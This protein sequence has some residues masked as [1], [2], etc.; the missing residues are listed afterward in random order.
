MAQPVSTTSGRL[1]AIRNKSVN[2]QIFRAL[3]SLASA[4]LLIRVMGMLNQVVV[5]S[6]FGAGP[7]MDAYVIASAMP[8]LLASLLGGAIESS[9][10][11]V[12]ARV[13]AQGTK[14]QT[15]RLFSTLLNLF[16]VCTVLVTLLM[17]LFRAQV[18]LLSAPGSQSSIIELAVD[19]AP[20]IFPAFVLMVVINY[21]ECILNTEG[22]FGWP[23]YAGMLV[24]LTTAI[25]VFT[26][27]RSIGVVML[28]VGMMVGLCL[29]LCAFI[30]RARRAGLVY[31]F[32]LEVHNPEIGAIIRA[33]WPVLVGALIGQASNLIDIIFSSFLPLG[34]ISALNYSLK[35]TSVFTGVIFASVGRAVLPY[36]SR[37]AS[38]NDMKNFKETLRLYIWI[39]GIGTTILSVLMVVLAH[40]MVH[41]L[42]QRGAFT[43]NDTNRTAITFIG[44]AVGLTPIAFG[45]I[46]FRAFSALGKTRVLLRVTLFSL[47][48]NAIFDYIF[49]RIWQS[50]G[51]ALATSATYVC[52]T[53]I[54]F[55]TLRCMIG[56]LHMF[57]PPSEIVDILRK[58]SIRLG[59]SRQSVQRGGTFVDDSIPMATGK[60]AESSP[61][62]VPYS[63]RQHLIRLGI[64]IAVF[65][66]GVAGVFLNSLYALRISLASVIMLVLMRYN[67]VLLL[68]WIL[69]NGPNAIPI[70]RGTNIIVGLTAPTLL[71]MASM[72]IKQT[73]KRL[74]ALGWL[75]IYLLWVSLSINISPFGTGAALTAWFL[76]LD[77]VTVSI[78][79]INALNTRRRLLVVIDAML[80]V[81]ACIALYGIY[82]LLTKQN[83]IVDPST[84]LFRTF[85]IFST[86]TG[87]ALFLSLVIPLALYRTF[88]LQGLM[89]II[90]VLLVLLFVLVTGLTFTRST[91]ISVP[92]SL[93]IMA[94][95]LPSREMRNALFSSISLVAVIVVLLGTIGNVPI[96][97]RF[98]GQDVSTLN[99]RTFLW[100]TILNNFDPTQVL[101][102]GLRASDAL[103]TNLFTSGTNAQRLTAALTSSH[104]LFLGTLYDHGIIGLLLLTTVF[105]ALATS[106]IK[107]M[108][109]SSGE[110]RLLFAVALAVLASVFLQSFDS[111]DFWDQAISIYIWVILVLPFAVYWSKPKQP[112]TE[113]FIEELDE[114]TVKRMKIVQQAERE[115]SSLVSS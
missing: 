16:I 90:G 39:V 94:A 61:F 28:C 107:G 8:I 11:P 49:A 9:I 5:S 96:F 112:P 45:F 79:A 62:R 40:P 85:S 82:S 67:Y 71:L 73:I 14:E 88:T 91:Y 65:A 32:I 105:I 59:L 55:F 84:S 4:A 53:L 106:I 35:L 36:L 41:L 22:Q 86:A 103:L 101:G 21:L 26:A 15:I 98:T 83:G 63:V 81:S 93:L 3:L 110:R 113:I 76:R 19:L 6:R 60:R 64:M 109:K 30:I 114:I 47:V 46:V 78:L 34:S 100:Q 58:A 108:R 24:P 56:E 17:L 18:M 74:P 68:S 66:T 1:K 33:G 89:R 31:R 77:C 13:R 104:N 70:F 92:M 44:F 87:L 51:I 115:Q 20:F 72:P 50:E 54:L 2:R 52:S 111:N 23:A 99:G 95:F 29:Q 42:F 43:A 25:F 69:I 37:Q 27:G 97:S 7:K 38:M 12:Y 75:C 48:A 80:L 57:T 102:K 10:V